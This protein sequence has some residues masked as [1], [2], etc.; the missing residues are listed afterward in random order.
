MPQRFWSV[1]QTRTSARLESWQIIGA[2]M[3]RTADMARLAFVT[4]RRAIALGWM[5]DVLRLPVA[6]RLFRM[7]LPKLMCLVL[8]AISSRTGWKTVALRTLAMLGTA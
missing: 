8:T 7:V 1:R 3:I 6:L 5:P 2:A 4:E